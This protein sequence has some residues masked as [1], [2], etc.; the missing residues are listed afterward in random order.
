MIRRNPFFQRSVAE[1]F[2]LLQVFSSHDQKTPQTF[3]MSRVLPENFSTLLDEFVASRRLEKPDENKIDAEHRSLCACLI[4]GWGAAGALAE[5]RN[6]Q[7]IR[8]A[9]SDSSVPIHLDRADEHIAQKP[10]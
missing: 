6:G 4:R 1:Q 2:V 5:V 10:D 7:G 8:G 3:V 9:E